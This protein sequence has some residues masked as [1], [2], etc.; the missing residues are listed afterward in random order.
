MKED[1]LLFETVEA[2]TRE[3]ETIMDYGLAEKVIIERLE[4]LEEPMYHGIVSTMYRLTVYTPER[5][6][7]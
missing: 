5:S 1:I 3:A 6:N 4:I 2:V 7:S